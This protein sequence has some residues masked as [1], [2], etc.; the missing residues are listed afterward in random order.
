MNESCSLTHTHTHTLILQGLLV[1]IPHHTMPSCGTKILLDCG[2]G[3]PSRMMLLALHYQRMSR[4]KGGE[5]VGNNSEEIDL[6][7]NEVFVQMYTCVHC[8]CDEFC[9]RLQ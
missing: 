5:G 4:S 6:E 9:E 8:M 3:C 7:G 2:E 1:N